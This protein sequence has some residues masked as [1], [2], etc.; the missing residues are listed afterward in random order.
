MIKK[1][2]CTS[3]YHLHDRDTHLLTPWPSGISLTLKTLEIAG[4]N[5]TNR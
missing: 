2:N 1:K 3:Q 5:P 4:S